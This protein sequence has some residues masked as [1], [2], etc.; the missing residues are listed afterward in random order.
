MNL[1]PFDMVILGQGLA[2]TALAWCAHWAKLRIAIIDRD[3]AVTSSKISAGL[4]TPITG[5]RLTTAP[6]WQ[7]QW[8][9]AQGFYRRVELLTAAKSFRKTAMVRLLNTTEECDFFAKRMETVDF[10]PLV[11]SPPKPA[12]DPAV[13][14]PSRDSFEMREGGQLHVAQYLAASKQFFQREQAYYTADIDLTKDIVLREDGVD[15]PR[16]HLQAM[17][18]VFCQGYAGV[19]NPWFDT[20]PFNP[21]KGEMLTVRIPGLPEERVIHGG[22]WLAPLGNERFRVGATYDWSHFDNV[23]TASG[24]KELETRLREALR[25]PYIVEEHHAAVRPILQTPEP[26]GGLH[27]QWPQLGIINGLASK[28]A[29]LAPNIAWEFLRSIDADGSLRR[30]IGLRRREE[31]V[32][33]VPLTEIAHR[34]CYAQKADIVIDATAG[35]GHDTLFLAESVGPYGKVYAFDIQQ[36]ALDQTAARLQAAQ[37]TNVRLICADHAQMLTVVEPRHHGRISTVMFNLGYLPRGDKAIITHPAS[38]VTA[39]RA[40]M[41]LLRDGGTL[42]ILAYPGHPGGETELA[43]VEQ[44][45]NEAQSEFMVDRYAG[46]NRNR[47]SPVLLVLKK[48]GAQSNQNEPPSISPPLA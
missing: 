27:P 18:L 25:V 42:T 26:Y 19:S 39:I 8:E 2:G 14:E 17:R 38:T 41:E 21:A 1:P 40:A 5:K 30:T 15:L 37:L 48:C 29:L 31:L 35:N 34:K 22:V 32:R 10:A 6:D 3:E 23:P 45:V 33:M 28:G 13:F 20:L 16:F 36:A 43:A 47:A 46:N 11:Q 7:Q 9:V 12:L 44:L 24:R 4:M